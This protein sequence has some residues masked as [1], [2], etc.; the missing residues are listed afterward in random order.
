[1]DDEEYEEYLDDA[2]DIAESN[3]DISM[4]EILYNDEHFRQCYENG[5]DAEQAVLMLSN[6]CL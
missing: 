4:E 5:T 6:F 1:M 2:I 3:Y